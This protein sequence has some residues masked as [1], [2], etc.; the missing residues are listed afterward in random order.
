MSISYAV[1]GLLGFWL[2]GV[3]G[4]TYLT[5]PVGV[6]APFFHLNINFNVAFSSGFESVV[7]LCFAAVLSYAASGW[8]TGAAL[9]LLF[10]VVA[11]QVGGIDAKYFSVSDSTDAKVDPSNELT[12]LDPSSKG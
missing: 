5:L 9:A 10:N 6:I 8:L 1:F 11:K 12:P 4:A 2:S 7:Y 3:T